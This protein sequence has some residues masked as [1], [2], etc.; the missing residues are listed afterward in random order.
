MLF[1]AT[2]KTTFAQHDQTPV[3]Q[4]TNT[5][6]S[7]V[8]DVYGGTNIETTQVPQPVSQAFIT[9]YPD[10]KNAVWYNSSRGYIATYS[11]ANGVYEGMWYDKSGKPMGTIKRVQ[12][13]SLS[14]AAA[15]N[16]KKKYPNMTSEYVYEVLSPT[17]S[18]SYVMGYDGKWPEFND[19]GMYI[20]K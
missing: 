3:Q 4:P 19:T 20:E 5:M 2:I 9:K 11:S 12:F 8:W 15:S 13:S 14:P 17:G 7:P 10:R 1:A 6:Q 16:I 18:R